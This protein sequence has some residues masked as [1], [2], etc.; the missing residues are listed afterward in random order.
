MRNS[1]FWAAVV[2]GLSAASFVHA[3]FIPQE[4]FYTK[5]IA[6]PG[7]ITNGTLIGVELDSEVFGN[8]KSDLGDLRIVDTSGMEVPYVLRSET[9]KKEVVQYSPKIYDL[10]YVAGDHTSFIVDFGGNVAHNEISILTSSKNFRR[11]ATISGS[12]D[13]T[14]WQ[15]IVSGRDIYDYSLEFVARDVSIT[16]PESLYRYVQVRIDDNGDSPLAISGVSAQRF[17]VMRAKKVSYR[18]T[19][20]QREEG[21]QT[22]IL[23]DLLQRGLET[24]TA[25]FAI[26]SQNFQRHVSILSSDDN[27]NWM[28]VGDDVV[29]SYQTSKIRSNKSSVHFSSVKQRYLRFVIDNYDNQPLKIENAVTLEGLAHSILFLADPNK[30]YGLYYGYAK[31][32]MP[33]YDFESVYQHFDEDEIV[34][35][36][37]DIQKQSPLYTPPQPVMV[38]KP[39]APWT[40]KY[41]STLISIAYACAGGLL[42][43]FMMNIFRRTKGNGESRM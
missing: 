24:D 26:S 34:R 43:F 12:N 18:P 42:V 25:T 27:K 33:H 14:H 23:A 16:Y 10:S 5:D 29:Y 28:R 9:T 31:G 19:V 40:E 7:G 22:I 38:S 17:E 6:I 8:A 36:T 1:I 3:D 4:W 15:T 30:Q 21:K 2:G 11:A 35:G 20:T 32:Y 41:A 37:L 13:R 39:V